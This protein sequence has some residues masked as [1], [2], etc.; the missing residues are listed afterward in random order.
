MRSNHPIIAAYS[1]LWREMIHRPAQACQKRG[2]SSR[3]DCAP[4]ANAKTEVFVDVSLLRQV[5]CVLRGAIGQSPSRLAANAELQDEHVQQECQKEGQVV[6]FWV[7]PSYTRQRKPT[8]I[9]D[10]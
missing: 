5:S 2:A 1:G 8:S 9:F 10:F 7:R 6:K 4:P 3:F